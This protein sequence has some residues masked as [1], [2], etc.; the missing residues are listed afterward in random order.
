MTAPLGLVWP[1]WE[2]CGPSSLTPIAFLESII[3]C[4]C[5]FFQDM[6]NVRV[7]VVLGSGDENIASDD[8]T[9]YTSIGMEEE[10]A[11]RIMGNSEPDQQSAGME[12]HV[13]RADCSTGERPVPVLAGYVDIKYKQQQC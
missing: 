8:I 12:S 4:V 10:G 3:I 6:L 11:D 13:C 2:L 5:L 9:V 7:S 1:A